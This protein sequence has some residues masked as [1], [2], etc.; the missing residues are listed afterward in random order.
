MKKIFYLL[1]FLI[2][3]FSSQAQHAACGTDLYTEKLLAAQQ[4]LYQA[5]NT[6]EEHLTHVAQEPEKLSKKAV[7]YTIPVVF[8]VMH[9]YGPE[10]ISKE[11][12]EDQMKIL[13]DDFQRLNADRTNTRS[14]FSGV[15]ADCEIEFKLARIDP[16]GNCTEGINRVYSPLTDR[17]DDAVKSVPGANWDRRK[18]LNIWVVKDIGMGADEGGRVLGYATLPYFSQG[19]NDGIVILSDY[20][21]SIGTSNKGRAGRT[22]T[23]EVGHWLGLYH[24]FQN[25]CGG[26]CSTTGDRIC[27]T[28]PVSSPSFGC[29]TSNNTCSNDVPNQLDQVENFMDYANGSCMNMFTTG[30]KNVMHSVL[31]DSRYRSS[32]VSTA[33]LA[34]TG[35]L[36]NPSCAPIADFYA[37]GELIICQ[38]QSI[39]FDNLSYNGAIVNNEWTFEGGSPSFSTFEAP[40]VTYNNPGTFKVTLKVSNASGES[41]RTRDAFVTVLPA[42]SPFQAPFTQTF[43]DNTYQTQGYRLQT[44]GSYGWRISNSVG[45]SGARS[46]QAFINASTPNA[47]RYMAYL[48]P[49]NMSKYANLNP[50]LNFYTAYAQR[51]T[52][53]SEILIV[54]VSD[55]CGERWKVLTSMTAQ[56]NL[57]STSTPTPDWFPRSAADWRE[58]SLDLSEYRNHPNLFIRFEVMSRQGNSVYIDNINID[59]FTLGAE[60]LNSSVNIFS[61]YPNPSSKGSVE[62]LL[63]MNSNESVRLEIY[64]ARG[65][66]VQNVLHLEQP[67]AS[68]HTLLV[69]GLKKGVYFARLQTGDQQL[70]R[71]IIIL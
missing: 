66:L 49:V 45:L 10:N 33:N 36:T 28:P 51:S 40:Q 5:R 31:S 26:N 4:H 61:V 16:N 52:D 47:T 56:R 55:D 23:H 17:G 59:Q 29:P 39:Q 19:S 68:E 14:I 30:Q 35:V 34:A 43:D 57:S 18:Y 22:L 54:G 32:N 6:F 3:T 21:G 38:G 44:D 1:S 15:A 9:T 8:H 67:K 62:I 70:I 53:A 48:P 2:I 25:G 11:Q 37:Q 20:V 46:L 50:K 63:G 24:P 64:D 13:N 65:V 7:K 60:A 71:K 69:D 42:T 41:S 58:Q 12:I 27:D